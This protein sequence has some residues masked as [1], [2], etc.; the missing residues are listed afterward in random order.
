MAF[1]FKIY[2]T[3][4]AMLM[5][6]LKSCEI[7]VD[8]VKSWVI[9]LLLYVGKCDI[10]NIADSFS[11]FFHRETTSKILT[12]TLSFRLKIRKK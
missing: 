3:F 12:F 6:S 4:T 7:D 10:R 5:D 1:F 11:S 2:P 9:G 8:A